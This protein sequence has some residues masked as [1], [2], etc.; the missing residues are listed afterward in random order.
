MKDIQV[1]KLIA[2]E[3]K[4]QKSVINLIASENYVSNDVLEALGT[5][6]TNKYAEGYPGARYYGGNEIIDQI[7]NLAKARALKLFGLSNKKWAV[8]VQ[9][10]SGSP[11][12]VAVYLGLLPIGGKIM[13]MDLTNGGHLTHGHKVSITGKAWTQIPFAVDSKTEVIDYV[14][15]KKL[16]L[17]EKPNI[18]VAGFTA[19]PRRVDWKKFR[20]IA[21][22]C[23]AYLMVDMSHI[24][25]LIAGKHTHHRFRMQ[26]W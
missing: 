2:A 8:N 7:E 17:A 24:A 9:P 26:M 13:G 6:L 25:G 4:R 5:E 23:G 22:A 12:N 16:A 14:K 15:L 3:Q 10:L 1:K 18:I 11:A 19:Y 20:D 21:D